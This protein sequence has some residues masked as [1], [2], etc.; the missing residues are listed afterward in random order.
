MDF[1]TGKDKAKTNKQ[2]SDDPAINYTGP[3]RRYK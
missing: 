2:D 3:C 1:T